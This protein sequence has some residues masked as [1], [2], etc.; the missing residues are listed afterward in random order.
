MSEGT[1]VKTHYLYPGEIFAHREPHTVTTV[2]GSCVSV[3]LWDPV[4]RLG[5]INHFLLPLWNG[6]GLPTPKYGN[7]AIPRLLEKL[8]GL[9]ASERKLQAKV[10]GGA[11]MWNLTD[12]LLA[13]G[14]RNVELAENVLR[15]LGIPVVGSDLGG[16]QSRKII[17]QTGE[18]TVL[19]RR[20]R[21]LQDAS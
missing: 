3:C 8:V 7:I 6:D 1:P 12:G 15:E 18:G 5:G 21:G 10:F 17:F 2:L 13:V 4:A 16:S 14:A 9:G 20:H 11:A 19:L